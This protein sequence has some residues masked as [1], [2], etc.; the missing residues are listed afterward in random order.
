MRAFK[1]STE[2]AARAKAAEIDEAFGYP[3]DETVTQIGPGRHAPAHLTRTQRYAE[4]Q[5]TTAGEWAVEIDTRAEAKLK[6][7][8][9]AALVTLRDTDLRPPRPAQPDRSPRA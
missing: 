8:D 4:P 1:L 9:K 3:K 5:T 2:E 6:P 7:A